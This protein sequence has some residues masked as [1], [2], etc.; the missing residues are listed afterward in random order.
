M[1]YKD[2]PPGETIGRI[3][4]ILDSI[5]IRVKETMF[6]HN[7]LSFSCRI[8]VDNPGFSELNIGTNGKGLTEEYALA[9]GYAEFMERL[10]N[11]FLINEAMR[12]AGR[13]E[14]EQPLPFRFFPDEI[15]TSESDTTEF[16][17]LISEIFPSCKNEAETFLRQSGGA[18]IKYRKLPYACLTS[19]THPKEDKGEKQCRLEYLPITLVRGNSSTGMCAGNTPSEAIMQGICEIYERY[20]L[21]QIYLRPVTPPSFPKDYFNGTE[22]GKRLEELRREGY[23][24]EVKD[25]SLGKNLPVIGLILTDPN[26]ATMVR[27]GSDPDAGIALER[28]ITEIFQG[29]NRGIEKAFI[30]YINTPPLT[31]RDNSFSTFRHEY[32]KSLKDGTGR[33]PEELFM[34][35][36]TYPL[37]EWAHRRSDSSDADLKEEISRLSRNGFRLLVRDNSFLGFCTYHVYI[38]GLSEQHPDLM[39]VVEDYLG[40]LS[41]DSDGNLSEDASD[42]WP[43]YNI[44]GR[45]KVTGDAIK[46]AG[47][48][49]ERYAN[50]TEI[51][52]APWNTAA[53]NRINKN[54]L[55]FL[56][57][58]HDRS[59]DKA[60]EWL[61]RFISEREKV[62]LNDNDYFKCWRDTLMLKASPDNNEL[63]EHISQ[64]YPKELSEEVGKEISEPDVMRNF[65]FPTCFNCRECPLT[66]ECRFKAV[67]KLERW[68]QKA[69]TEN[70]IDQTGLFDIMDEGNRQP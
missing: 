24:F 42:I 48:V 23:T 52:L 65:R 36:P 7:R 14:G 21:Q 43:L 27:L 25:M 31:D 46:L 70:E 20:V 33:Y 1:R 9:S 17:N 28:C 8:T 45:I 50:D 47:F 15:L 35:E 56:L 5:G 37:S 30:D 41:R 32:R 19:H 29:D 3:R 57:N 53:G 4:K 44:K 51:K 66:E 22:A 13:I 54:L 49:E 63:R 67:V 64:A 18:K 16:T 62:G 34:S 2:S 58:T 11:K 6:S 61:S 39:P 60:A 26:G 38:P 59:Y 10:Q 69:Q 40:S 55:L 68:L 12:F